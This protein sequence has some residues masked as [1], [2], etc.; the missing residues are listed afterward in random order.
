[1][2]ALITIENLSHAFGANKVLSDISLTIKKGSYT[3][4]LGPSGS[5][6]TTLLSVLGGFLQPDHGRYGHD[7]DAAR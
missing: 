1:M 2:S 3:V 7:V 5:G 6:K 4:L